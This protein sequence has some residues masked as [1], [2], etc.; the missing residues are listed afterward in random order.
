MKQL[1]FLPRWRASALAAA[2]ALSAAA[3][4]YAAGGG[5]IFER[6]HLTITATAPATPSATPRLDRAPLRYEVEHRGEDALQLDS[7]QA[8]STL[9][10]ETGVLIEL[11]R[12]R[13]LALPALQGESPVDVLLVDVNG[14]ILK[15]MPS[16]LL[17]ESKPVLEARQP[18]KAFVFLK[19]GEA[20]LRGIRPRDRV[21]GSMFSAPPMVEE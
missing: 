21:T 7:I 8:L 5:V 18:I 15:I 9:T 10:A 17:S 14:V 6:T 13:S 3:A 16:L 12:P 19:S 20:A 1:R 2:V 11:S 4:S